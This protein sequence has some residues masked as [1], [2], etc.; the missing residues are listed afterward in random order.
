MEMEIE[1]DDLLYCVLFTESIYG[2]EGTY[3]T[4]AYYEWEWDIDEITVYEGC[5]GN[6][7]DVYIDELP[8]QHQEIINEKINTKISDSI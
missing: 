2:D 3:D 1:I 8:E 5:D 4:P 6:G 7:R